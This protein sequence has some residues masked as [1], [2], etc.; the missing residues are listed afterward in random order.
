MAAYRDMSTINYKPQTQMVMRT[1]LFLCT[2]NYY[3]S[4]LLKSCST[5]APRTTD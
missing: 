3:R 1:A 2:G 4:R 5:I